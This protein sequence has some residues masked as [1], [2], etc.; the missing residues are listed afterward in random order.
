[1][2]CLWNE[3]IAILPGWM[4]SEVDNLGK[5]GLQELRLRLGYGPELIFQRKSHRLKR[6]ITKEDLN[7]VINMACRYS[8]WTSA[9]ISEGYLTATGGHRI[10]V[11]GEM[12]TG[13]QGS[14]TLQ[15]L[16][17]LCVRVARDYP[18]IAEPLGDVSGSILIIGSPGTGKTTLLRD[19][20]RHRNKLG[21]VAVVDERGELFP[22]GGFET[23]NRTDVLRFSS[24][25]KGIDMVLRSMGPSTIAVDEITSQEDC[26]ALVK[27]GWCGVDLLATA[28]ARSKEELFRR[29]V[30]KPLVRTGIFDT[31]VVLSSNQSWRMERICP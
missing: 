13:E 31:L 10:G 15:N 21:S 12:R 18:G 22:P 6:I 23:G 27:A 8:P 4:R 2:K 26:N 7:Y 16:T 14:V 19:L 17:S 3:L 20:I 24:K 1:M 5:E 28:H 11:C 9:S 29:E 25:A 30:Y